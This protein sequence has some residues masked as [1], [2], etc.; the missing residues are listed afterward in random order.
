M[1]LFMFFEPLKMGITLFHSHKNASLTVC[2]PLSQIF[3][4]KSTTKSGF[5]T[6][7]FATHIVPPKSG[8]STFIAVDLTPIRL[9]NFLNKSVICFD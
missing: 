5:S 4:E 7:L 2:I 6:F 1:T 3:F 9:T 8:L